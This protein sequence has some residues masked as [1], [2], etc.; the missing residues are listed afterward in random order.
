MDFVIK[1][2]TELT[3]EEKES[4][5]DCFIEV[6]NHKRT[7]DEMCNQYINT[8]MGYSVHSLCFD[9]GKIVAA[10]T[11]FPSYYWVGDQKVKVYI[12]GDTMV[13]KEYRDGAVYL[14]ITTD[15]TAFMKRNGYSFTFGFP[16]ESSYAVNKK[17]HLA[18]E[19]GRLDIFILPY[20]IGGIKSSMSWLNPFSKLF[21]KLWLLFS[22]IG[23]KDEACTSIVHK[24]D[25][26]YNSTRYKRLDGNYN[27]IQN[28]GI[29]FYFKIKKHDGVRTAFL[30]DVIGKSEKSFQ[31]AV[32][33]ILETE[34][35][36]FDLLMYVGYLPK[37]IR[38]I[39]LIKIPHKI[40]PKHF[41]MTGK[42]LD[43]SFNA[44][45]IY[46][47]NSWDVNLSDYDLI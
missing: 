15:L 45:R 35:K 5:L 12:T 25:E 26:T 10:H 8:P 47:I 37:K 16:N 22:A 9:E 42:V 38:K 11:A 34:R 40:E 33:Y 46:D 1:K 29:E 44:K 18:V 3:E 43:K 14:D 19:I 13:R 30:I 24:D 21:C 36:N 23:A 27:H 41:Y 39:G 28:N 6:F 31:Y 20:R 7:L 17:G 32:K 4:L 2:T